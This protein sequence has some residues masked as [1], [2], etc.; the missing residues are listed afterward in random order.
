MLTA[1][2]WRAPLRLTAILSGLCT[3]MPV[4]AAPTLSAGLIADLRGLEEQ[5][6]ESPS[7]VEDKASSQAQRLAGGNDSDRWA[8]ALYLQLAAGAEAAQDKHGEAADHLAEARGVSGVDSAQRS[9]W[10]RQE[11]ELRLQAGQ[12]EQGRALLGEWLVEHNEDAATLWQMAQL[13]ADVENWEAAA[14]WVAKAREADAAPTTEQLA[15]SAA[16]MQRSGRL[17]EALAALQQRLDQSA[18]DPDAWR[19][20][21]GLAQQLG[22]PVRA[23][24]IWEAGWRQG[25][26]EGPDDLTRRIR[27]QLAAG[28]PARAAEMLSA[29]LA[30]GTLP[31]DEE[32]LRLLAESWHLARDRGQALAAWQRLAEMTNQASDWMHLG[33][34]ATTWGEESI[35]REALALAEE[36]GAEQVGEWR[37]LLEDE[38]M[39]DEVLK[40]LDDMQRAGQ[41]VKM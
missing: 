5:L 35:A 21:A 18:D 37:A 8:S 13:E 29:A 2:S 23:A 6:S 27:L 28:T 26:L 39:P 7:A 19:R 1:R 16:V 34:L 41:Q 25:L 20:A 11:A 32:H 33:Q 12:A 4:T 22:D 24:S 14:D 36:R 31:E 30:D 38:G 15:F 3:A 40:A 17:D 10:L 9:R